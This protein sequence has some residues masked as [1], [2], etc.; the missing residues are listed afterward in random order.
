MACPSLKKFPTIEESVLDKYSVI[1]I[2]IMMMMMMMMMT[3]TSVRL[4][5]C[6]VLILNSLVVQ[7]NKTV[8]KMNWSSVFYRFF[9]FL[10]CLERII[11]WVQIKL[12]LHL[13]ILLEGFPSTDRS[14]ESDKKFRGQYR[15]WRLIFSKKK[16]DPVVLYSVPG[17]IDKY[18]STL[19][20]NKGCTRL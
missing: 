10:C 12:T 6:M 16:R 3:F 7:N 5:N 19:S 17:S 15:G 14:S 8:L 18:V 13:S 11:S 4:T 20:L 1:I 2:I 9:Y